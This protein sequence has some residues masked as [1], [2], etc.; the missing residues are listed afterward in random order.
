MK[1]IYL[2][3]PAMAVSLA[4][5]SQ[6][7]TDYRPYQFGFK[8]DQIT[9]V[10]GGRSAADHQRG[11]AIYW[12]EDFANGFAGNNGSSPSTWTV[13]G[14][15]G[16]IWDH[17]PS[18]ANGCY[19]GGSP[20]PAFTTLN[21]GFMV[22]HG[23]SANCTN[24]G[25]PPVATS[26]AWVGELIS[27]VIDLSSAPAVNLQFEH[28]FRYC[29]TSAALFTVS[30][31]N[32]GG[33]SWTDYDV[34]NGVA[35]NAAS[36]NPI[37]Q[38]INI[39]SVA[40]GSSTVQ[41][42]FTWSG[43]Q[44]HYYWAV[45]DI[46][47]VESPAHELGFTKAGYGVQESIW[48]DFL[49]YRRIPDEQVDEIWFYGAI[50][51]QGAS[52]ENNVSFNVSV[53]NSGTTVVYTG[54]GVGA[55]SL[56]IGDTLK[57]TTV[58]AFTPA[59]NV[60]SYTVDYAFNYTNFAMDFNTA[61]NV[62]A[63]SSFAV[64]DNEYARDRD[65]ASTG[66][67]WNSDDGSGVANPFIMGAEY[68]IAQNQNMGVVRVALASATQANAIIYPYVIEVDLAATDFQG[69]FANV[70]YDGSQVANGTYTVQTSDISSGTSLVEVDLLLQNCLTLEA[71]KVYV[72]GVGSL[73]GET[74][75]IMNANIDPADAT[76]F[77]YDAVG[78]NNGNIQWF[79]IDNTPVIRAV[80][81][82]C[83]GLEE[84]AAN[85][86][87]LGQNV[88][89]PFNGTTRIDYNLINSGN[90]VFT[91]VDLTGKV[92]M[93]RNMGQ[94]ASGAYTLNIESGD[95]S[96]GTYYYTLSVD[97]VRTTKRMVVE[98]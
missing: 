79:W 92:V 44:S 55:G 45:D 35:V 74:V 61:N 70:I 87:Q 10:E 86:F 49:D 31:S 27:P 90:V 72:I 12:T 30:V 11:G 66:Y 94:Q 80:F 89:N 28:N 63:S 26:N 34:R 64:T 95:L 48:G 46:A 4:G 23:D 14:V 57:D 19:S 40:A 13:S 75:G 81:D 50:N 47:I 51:N 56:A 91:V 96:A 37:M 39:S 33:T 83:V 84:E 68:T 71:G 97:G 54:T 53:E 6:R 36:A 38:D 41:I 3:L 16:A 20:D 9:N 59:P 82:I 77:L 24:P 52:V 60:E 62:P 85:G 7:V 73:G 25:P 98:K 2:L 58:T 21:N 22:F 76:V 32:N 69:L 1:K 93:E 65:V 5:F 29:C 15:D 78:A 88:P 8:T 43:G 67:L 42:K 17:V 18:L